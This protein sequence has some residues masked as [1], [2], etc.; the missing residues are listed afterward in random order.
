MNANENST[1]PSR[2]AGLDRLARNLWWSWQP[3]ARDLFRHIGQTLWMRSRKNPVEMLRIVDQERLDALAADP[4]FLREYDGVM[5]GFEAVMAARRTW[6]ADAGVDLGQGVAYFC[7][8][9]GVHT[10][11]P[12]YSGGLGILAGDHFKEGSDLGLPLVGVGFLYERGY[13]RQRMGEHGEQ[14]AIDEPFHPVSMPLER[15]WGNGDDGAHAVVQLAEREIHL[16]VWRLR[17]GHTSIFLL[18]TD[19]EWNDPEDRL[20]SHQ[21]YRGDLEL[22]LRQEIV[23]GIGGV[24]VLRTLG[25]APDVWHANEGHAAFMLLERIKERVEAGESAAEAMRGVAAATVFTTH[26]P[27]PAGHDAFP[28]E[29]MDRYFSAYISRL[30]LDPEAFYAL[31]RHPADDGRYHMSALALRLADHRNGVSRLHGQVARRMWKDL[32]NGEES[33]GNQGT[34]SAAAEPEHG[35]LADAP[36]EEEVPIGHITNGIHVPSW[37]SPAFRELFDRHFG[38]DW[39]RSHDDPDLW[40]RALD[41][42]DE[43]IWRAHQECKARLFG[44]L[45]QR[46]RRRWQEEGSAADHVVASGT[47]LDPEVLTIDFARR[48]ATYKRATLIFRDIDRLERILTSTWRPV[49]IVFAG[50]AHPADQPGQELLGDVYRKAMDRRFGGRIA[51]IE[52]YDMNVARNLYSGVDV[53][54]NNPRPPMEA[55]GTSGQKAAINGVPQLSTLDGWWAEGWTG[56]N[57]WA[58]NEHQPIDLSAEPHARDEG[59]AL[60]LYDI[61]ENE[62]AALYY[63]RDVDGVP[64]GW[65]RVMKQAIRAGGATFT[66]RRMVKEYVE[67][68]YAPAARASRVAEPDRAAVG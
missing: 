48:F 51:F 55:C 23:L 35:V 60:S 39:V 6:Y 54:L 11:I 62:V 13:F 61:L 59:D 15:V 26:T 46:A 21:L 18:D 67:R 20:L 43:L 10:S 31:G 2:I 65:I 17:I 34:A 36:S 56:R 68:F 57:G 30:G 22:R 5:A 32:W 12:I 7:A 42:P 40:E 19:I 64:R 49:Q 38:S 16:G 53:W 24:R 45:R 44:V 8:E 25:H 3:E 9:F 63:K 4:L 58:I 50:K 29:M 47:L 37:V 28:R 27:V 14:I 52:D 41:L 1:L 33:S 66:A